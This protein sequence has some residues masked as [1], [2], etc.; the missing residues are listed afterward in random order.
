MIKII[1]KTPMFFQPNLDI[2][3]PKIK[4]GAEACLRMDPSYMGPQPQPTPLHHHP[5]PN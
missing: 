2:L 4:G 5:L 1:T 3:S